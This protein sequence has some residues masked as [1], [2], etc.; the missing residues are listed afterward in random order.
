MADVQRLAVLTSG[1]DAP[2]MNAVVRAVV[3]SAAYLG[4]ATV[5]VRRGF[6]GLIR[7]EF[8]AMD[9][10]DVADIIHRGGTVLYTARSEA[11]LTPEGQETA[12]RNLRA[13]N[14]DGVVVVGGDG[15]LRGALSL[16]H[17]GVPTVGV[18]ATIDNDVVGAEPAIGF[19][20][21]ANTALEAIDR[22]RDTATAHERVFVVEVMGRRSGFLALEAG[23]AGGAECVLVPEIPYDMDDVAG[24]VREAYAIGKRHSI[25]IVAE[26]AA[27]GFEVGQDLQR[28][29]GLETRV[30]VLGH[31]QRGGTP[32]A[33]DRVL[34]SRLGSAAVEALVA[35]RRGV[36]VGS[37]GQ[38]VVETPYERVLERPRPI[39]PVAYALI[40]KLA[41]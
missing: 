29:T 17:L 36:M 15:S 32:S 30:T 37:I 2:G 18:P 3:R 33:V 40:G 14:V 1:G 16:E 34:G 27:H 28:R 23:L 38:Q 6:H 4:I 13:E 19:D 39:D 11:F 25:L 21:A 24:R 9:R 41:I 20:T 22:V 8:V 31:T 26:G 5:G 10:R 12:V 7:G 35:G